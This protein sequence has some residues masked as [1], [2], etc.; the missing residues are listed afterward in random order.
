MRFLQW[1]WRYSHRMHSGSASEKTAA[2]IFAME[3]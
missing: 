1:L 2:A 3:V